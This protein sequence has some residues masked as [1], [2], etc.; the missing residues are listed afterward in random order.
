MS[1]VHYLAYI[2]ICISVIRR[3]F[4][5]YLHPFCLYT[6]HAR[7]CLVRIYT[8]ERFKQFSRSNVWT[9]A[10]SAKATMNSLQFTKGCNVLRWQKSFQHPRV[11]T[12][13]RRREAS[14]IFFFCPSPSFSLHISHH[15]IYHVHVQYVPKVCAQVVSYTFPFWFR[16]SIVR[17]T[18]WRI[19][20]KQWY[21]K[22]EEETIKKKRT[23]KRAKR[24]GRSW[25]D[26]V[27]SDL[28]RWNRIGLGNAHTWPLGPSSCQQWASRRHRTGCP[29]FWN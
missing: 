13:V 12:H 20:C 21:K 4:C 15:F 3:Y 7:L 14:V 16:Q 29:F 26:M 1:T 5:P 6:F 8:I 9:F 19:T 27:E 24:G 2:S 28:A 11:S 10:S 22:Q 23:S 18:N 25:S 17:E